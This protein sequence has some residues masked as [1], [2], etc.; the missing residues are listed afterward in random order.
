MDNIPRFK[1]YYTIYLR[2]IRNLSE[3]SI[4][5]Y[6]DGI[7]WISRRLNEIGILDHT[8]F[9]V[10]DIETLVEAEKA[11]KQDQTY[12]E[13]N[14]RGHQMYSAALHNYLKFASGESFSEIGDDIEALDIPVEKDVLERSY[15]RK[16]QKRSG[17]VKL[18]ILEYANYTC[19]INPS[20][21]T[22]TSKGNGKRYM[23]GHHAIPL[24]LQDRFKNSL[25]VYANVLCL[26]PVCHRLV[27]YGIDYERE[28]ALKRIHS[29]R[30]RR[31]AKS[32]IVLTQSEFMELALIEK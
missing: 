25:D 21:I 3:S 17:I 9:D 29:L 15:I 16:E 5:H 31:L 28:L 12:V 8:L 32:G 13:L 1:K 6:I 26:C 22:F 4:A 30:S 20:H 19:E 14:K 2:E 7:N 18:Q 10:V 11:L 27:H 23:E 24:K